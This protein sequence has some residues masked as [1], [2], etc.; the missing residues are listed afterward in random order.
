MA[1]GPLAALSLGSQS[2]EAAPSSDYLTSAGKTLS[3]SDNPLAAYDATRVVS[4]EVF[5]KR[6]IDVAE[7]SGSSEFF[8]SLLRAAS[9]EQML[10]V[11]GP[12]TVFVPMD[13]AFA[14][15]SGEKISGLI[16]DPEALRSLV[17]R[18]VVPGRVSTTDLMSGKT[19]QSLAGSAVEPSVGADLQVNEAT[20][21]ATDVAENGVVH[22]ID[23]LL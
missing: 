11:E 6:L 21:V 12:Y 7:G 8:N 10:R 13:D 5:G 22:Y 23:R 14:N 15:M 2:R 3:N 20:V 17:E 18:H 9:L 19:V 4:S 16:H 1:L